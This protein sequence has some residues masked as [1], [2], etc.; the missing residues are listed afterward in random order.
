MLPWNRL[1]F[2]FSILVFASSLSAQSK[3][4]IEKQEDGFVILRDGNPFPIRGV[5]GVDHFELLSELGGNSVRCWGAEN[6]GTILDKAHQHGLTVCAGLWMEHPRHGFDYQN[7]ELV[8]GQL[9]KHLEVV[10]K[11]KDHPAL[12]MWAVGNEMEGEGGDPSIWYAVEH[13]A[14]RIKELDPMHPTITVIAELGNEAI[15]VRNIERFCPSIDAIGVNAYGGIQSVAE[16]YRAAGGSKPYIVTEH[17]PLGPWEVERTPW[18]SPVEWSS[19]EKAEF[20]ADGYRSNAIQSADL[21]LGTYAFLWGEKQETTATWFGMLLPDGERLGAVDALARVWGISPTPNSCP[22]LE[23]LYV[24]WPTTI[25]PGAKFTATCIASD[26]DNDPLRYVWVLRSD[27]S[28]IGEGGDAQKPETEFATA[29][30]ATDS[31]VTITIPNGGGGYRLFC[32]VFDD[33]RGAAVANV[34]FHVAAPIQLKVE[35]EPQDL[36][37]TVYGD[38]MSNQI[39]APSGYMGNVDAIAMQLDCRESPQQGATCLKAEYSSNSAWGGVLWQSPAED[40]EGSQPGGAN[41]TGATHLEFYARGASGNEKVNFVFGVLQ[42]NLEYPD[43]AKGELKDVNLSKEW[44]RYR[45]PL[46]ALDL[47][48][49]KTGFGW[50]LSAQGNPVK[51]YLDEIRYISEPEKP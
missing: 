9:T 4:S 29:I 36:P 46:G 12:L 41:L 21:C 43:T 49:I 26:P 13:V 35:M 20:Y 34:P 45:I 6:L 5:G 23:G 38:K 40:W 47:R 39:Y 15:K 32:Y 3:V 2:G 27:S 17:G 31:T 48:Q 18:G 1:V 22:E 11:F 25:E 8:W 37:L 7:D 50:S 19:S 51:F 30:E 33:H 14:R 28:T 42:G 44:Q 10:E 16:R 24:Q